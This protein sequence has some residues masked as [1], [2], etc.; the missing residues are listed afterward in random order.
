MGRPSP[1]SC[2]T[3]IADDHERIYVTVHCADRQQQD[4]LVLQSSQSDRRELRTG[5]SSIT[6]PRSH[7]RPPSSSRSPR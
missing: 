2:E 1:P 7:S 6:R 5:S 3:E 4:A